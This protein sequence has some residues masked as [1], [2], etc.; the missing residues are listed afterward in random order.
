V[1]HLADALA[2]YGSALTISAW[3]FERL[4]QLVAKAINT[5][6]TSVNLSIMNSSVR[7]LKFGLYRAVTAERQAL[8]N[9]ADM[10]K[11]LRTLDA[12]QHHGEPHRLLRRPAPEWQGFID[13][14]LLPEE[15]VA[16]WPLVLGRSRL[17][18][19]DDE[20]R[21]GIREYLAA[22][23]APTGLSVRIYEDKDV[24]RCGNA[25]QV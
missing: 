15:V 1:L 20:L 5:N 25:V 8:Q 12:K 22:H 16:E 13:V 10:P 24:E 19:L 6:Y 2:H 7:H 3:A 9:N 14:D 4:H 21:H 11:W 18:K 17:T 23:S